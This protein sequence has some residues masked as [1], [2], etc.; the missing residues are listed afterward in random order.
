MRFLFY[1]P[2]EYSFYSSEISFCVGILVK[3]LFGP[4]TARVTSPSAAG[5]G[6]S[7]GAVTVTA[8]F[9]YKGKTYK[10]TYKR[11]AYD[12]YYCYR[13]LEMAPLCGS[14]HCE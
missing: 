5:G 8:K 9:T 4:R 7:E 13:K 10:D 11:G 12:P 1:C 6:Y 2:L 3:R 14:A